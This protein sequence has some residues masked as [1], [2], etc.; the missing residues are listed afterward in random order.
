MVSRASPS[1]LAKAATRAPGEGPD[2]HR[3]TIVEEIKLVIVGLQHQ[4]V[5]LLEAVACLCG[6]Y[7]RQS[8]VVR[9]RESDSGHER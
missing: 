1:R 9:D 2:A 8:D 7:Q 5:P 4:T 3:L 6:L